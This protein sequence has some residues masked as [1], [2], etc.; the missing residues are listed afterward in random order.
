MKKIYKEMLNEIFEFD[1]PENAYDSEKNLTKYQER[2]LELLD[3]N[4]KEEFRPFGYIAINEYCKP[5]K[6]YVIHNFKNYIAISQITNEF[7]P[8]E[9]SNEIKIFDKN[10]IYPLQEIEIT[11]D[12]VYSYKF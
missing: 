6:S 7:E 10:R 9:V 5:G 3:Y 11:I 1:V 12:F 4:L 8:K 2:L